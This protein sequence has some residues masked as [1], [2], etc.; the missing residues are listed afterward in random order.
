MLPADVVAESRTQADDWMRE[1]TEKPKIY[2][3]AVIIV[4]LWLALAYV[5]WWWW[6]A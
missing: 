3:G 4:A 6:R 1:Q 2:I 5:G